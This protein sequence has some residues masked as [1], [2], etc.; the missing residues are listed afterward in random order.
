MET[1]LPQKACW[2]KRRSCGNSVK[3]RTKQQ[4]RCACR[5]VTIIG[6]IGEV[7]GCF[8]T[9]N[10]CHLKRY[11]G[12]LCHAFPS[13]ASIRQCRELWHLTIVL[14]GSRSPQCTI[15]ASMQAALDGE[16]RKLD[17]SKFETLEALIRQATAYTQFLGERINRPEEE[18]APEPAA[19]GKR[20]AGRQQRGG[21]AKKGPAADPAARLLKARDTPL[22]WPSTFCTTFVLWVLEVICC[23]LCVSVASAQYEVLGIQLAGTP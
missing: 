20:K 10:S 19:N 18:I 22:A 2:K 1:S 8:L 3:Q 14:I 23:T 4:S 9:S 5:S 17:D 16:G 12:H 21:A 15:H 6:A 11:V 13:V 7:P